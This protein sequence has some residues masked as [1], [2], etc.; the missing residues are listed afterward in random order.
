MNSHFVGAVIYAEDVTLLGPTRNSVMALLD[1]CSTCN[2]THDHDI[3]FN[4]S[5][6]A[7]VHFSCH[8]SSFLGRELSFMGRPTA[9]KFVSKFT[10]LAISI[11][12][13]DV[14]DHYISKTVLKFYHK[15]NQVMNDFKY[16]YRNIKPKWLSSC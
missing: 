3:I 9:I 14:T 12:N 16:L 8:Q 1:I 11:I 2:Y 6:T 10:F 13:N 15:A 5:K 7:Y 4:L